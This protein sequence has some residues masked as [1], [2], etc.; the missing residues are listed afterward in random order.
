METERAISRYDYFRRVN[1]LCELI[2]GAL[3]TGAETPEALAGHLPGLL[4]ALPEYHAS[5][6]PRV[7]PD[8]IEALLKRKNRNAIGTFLLAFQQYL[9]DLT[10]GI[11][12]GSPVVSN[13]PF[14]SPEIFLGMGLVPCL[15]EAVPLIIA[16]ALTDGVAQELD[17]TEREGLPGHVCGFQRVPMKAIEKGLL[18]KPDLFVTNT[19]PCDSSNIMYHYIS[20]RLRVPVVW[21]DSPY[22]N[23]ARAFR[24]YLEEFRRMVEEL[25][26]A[27]GRTLDEDRLREHVEMGNEQLRYLYKLQDLR[28]H[29]PCPDPGMH[30]VLDTLAVMMCGVN[31]RMVEYTKTC[32]EEARA[33]V[34]RGT[35]FLPEGKREIRTLWTYSHLPNLLSLASW[36]EDEFGSTYLECPLSF[37][38][39]DRVG[40]VDTASVDSMLEG[41]AW[42]SFH[43]PM[44]RNVMGYSDVH[45]NEVVQIART[46]H[47][48]AALFGGNHTCKYAW[49]LPKILRDVLEDELGIPSLT[50][51]VDYMDARFAPHAS[52]K[53]ALG[54]FFRTQTGSEPPG[55]G[56]GA[57]AEAA[58]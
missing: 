32:Y 31:R 21:V 51:E 52:V 14:F 26:R 18:P 55:A 36:L 24:Y 10:D 15:S 47:A 19:A 22:Y 16:L 57:G 11:D 34:E 45:V 23:D 43:F 40:T 56:P 42:R 37:L 58:G 53:A 3:A 48:Q 29:A 12:R 1:A 8:L 25:E 30:R 38:P 35:T 50:Y 54:E 7:Y 44:H 17:E 39:G 46:Y 49:T 27:T 28:K 9:T 13:F 41:L 33:R 4:Q 2:T 6:I 5:L 20:E